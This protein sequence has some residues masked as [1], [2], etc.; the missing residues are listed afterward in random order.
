[1]NPLLRWVAHVQGVRLRRTLVL[2]PEAAGLRAGVVPATGGPPVR[3][4]VIGESTA[5]GCGARSHDEGFAG[6]FARV[7]VARAGRPVGWSVVGRRGATVL[8]VRHRLLPEV[9]TPVDVAVLMVGV[10][11]VLAGR[12]TGRWVEDLGAVLEGLLRWA[13]VVVVTGIAPFEAFPA[14]PRTLARSLAERAREFDGAS[15]ALCDRIP[16]VQ[17][18]SSDGLRAADPGFWGPDGFHPAPAGYARWA[19]TVDERLPAEWASR[20]R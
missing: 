15:R 19:A 18:V 10:N 1:M 11:D 16:G 2:S 3:L 7:L 20:F 12:T 9:D 13:P 14:L 17:W 8:L 4:L 6:S 5:A